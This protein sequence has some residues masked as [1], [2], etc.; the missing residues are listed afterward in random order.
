MFI[1]AADKRTG[2]YKTE[3]QDMLRIRNEEEKIDFHPLHILLF[4]LS[5]EAS[6]ACNSWG[7][8]C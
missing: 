4:F 6:A 8:I 7:S 1:F 5:S 2:G 3:G